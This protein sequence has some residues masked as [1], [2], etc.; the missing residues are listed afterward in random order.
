MACIPSWETAFFLESLYYAIAL[1]LYTMQEVYTPIP[2]QLTGLI[3]H[4]VLVQHSFQVHIH[5]HPRNWKSLYRE[6][7]IVA[8]IV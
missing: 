1:I 7:F 3:L 5:C 4:W 8:L 2:F 6:I